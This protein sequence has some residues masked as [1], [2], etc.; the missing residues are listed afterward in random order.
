[1]NIEVR[2]SPTDKGDIYEFTAE[3]QL[4]LEKELGRLVQES[5]AF[6]KKFGK[7]WRLTFGWDKGKRIKTPRPNGPGIDR[8]YKEITWVIEVPRFKYDSPRAKSYVPMLRHYLEGIIAILT[9]EQVDASQIQK[10]LPVLLKRFASRPGMLEYD[11]HPYTFGTPEDPY[12]M[13]AE[14]AASTQP[15]SKSK[16]AVE[17]FLRI[18]A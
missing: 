1:M 9:Q 14:A 17:V 5:E 10:A 4:W 12:G 11:P 15:A 6:I 16:T 18:A 3:F 13:E 2:A 7:D 8:K